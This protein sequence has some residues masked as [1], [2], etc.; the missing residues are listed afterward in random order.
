[1]CIYL[2]ILVLCREWAQVIL[3]EFQKWGVILNKT[4]KKYRLSYIRT[5]LLGIL[6]N[7]APTRVILNKNRE[8]Y[9]LSYIRIQFLGI[10]NN[11][12]PTKVNLNKNRKIFYG[13]K[14]KKENGLPHYVFSLRGAFALD[15]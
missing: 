13:E 1:M 7:T 4:Q 3:D 10:L 2:V 6:N 12:A 14:G 15:A 8:K 9:R 5:Q 11:T